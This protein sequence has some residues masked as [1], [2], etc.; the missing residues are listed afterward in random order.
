[1]CPEP[2]LD[3]MLHDEEDDVQLHPDIKACGAVRD[4]ISSRYWQR[5]M[6]PQNSHAQGWDGQQREGGC[7][8]VCV[9]PP[10][11]EHF[12]TLIQVNTILLV[13]FRAKAQEGRP[14]A[15]Q[16]QGGHLFS[17][18]ILCPGLRNRI[19]PPDLYPLRMEP[20]AGIS[21]KFKVFAVYCLYFA[22]RVHIDTLLFLKNIFALRVTFLIVCQQSF[23]K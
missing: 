2:F 21:L 14:D 12:W 6:M 20:S 19:T 3:I 23:A 16:V 13:K 4:L 10:T 15:D 17:S 8:C 11:H 22:Y 18:W 1:M 5:W 9:P 7:H